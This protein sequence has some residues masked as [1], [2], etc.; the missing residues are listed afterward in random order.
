MTFDWSEP[1][2]TYYFLGP[3]LEKVIISYSGMVSLNIL[4]N[5]KIKKEL[6]FLQW[7]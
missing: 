4:A 2:I 6:S 3:Y 7:D 1:N 5:P